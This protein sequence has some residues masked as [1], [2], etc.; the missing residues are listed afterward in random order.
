MAEPVWIP[1]SHERISGD[2][3]LVKRMLFP[4]FG[5]QKLGKY[6][7][8]MS[9]QG[10][11][12]HHKGPGLYSYT[13]VKDSPKKIRYYVDFGYT[14]WAE[15]LLK[16]FDFTQRPWIKRQPYAGE[17]PEDRNSLLSQQ[18]TF[19]YYAI[20]YSILLMTQT[21]FFAV[22]VG[23]QLI[24]LVNP[25]SALLHASEPLSASM[26][27]QFAA[28]LFVLGASVLILGLYTAT[29]CVCLYRYAGIKSIMRRLNTNQN[30]S[31]NKT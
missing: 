8:E 9:A 16:S 28:F 5:Y 25:I 27:F 7:E 31:S 11:H 6:L 17:R 23:S 2:H 26:V 4:F 30:S 24:G 15:Y 19:G 22:L 13:F 29:V 12:L 3:L 14:N 18:V 20:L 1:I 21:L 10:W